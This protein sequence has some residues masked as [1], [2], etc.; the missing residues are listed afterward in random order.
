MAATA[1][2]KLAWGFGG[3][4]MQMEGAWNQGGKSP[5]VFDTAYIDHQTRP[6]YGTPFRSADHYHRMKEDLGYLG[7]LGATAYRFSVAWTRILPNCTGTPN[8]E[9][10]KFYSDMIDEV[11]RQGAEP[12]LT[13]FHWDLPQ[14]CQD[15]FNGWQSDRIIEVFA[16]YANILFDNYGDRVNYWLTS[17]EP[18]ANCD[19]CMYRPKFPPFTTTSDAVYYQ[20]IHNSFLAHATVVR[21]ARARSDSANWKISIPNV[22]DW[23][24]PDPGAA[25]KEYYESTLMQIEWFFDPCFRGDYGPNI[26]RLLPLPEFTPAQQELMK[27]SCDYIGINIYNSMTNDL[28]ADPPGETTSYTSQE[29]GKPSAYWPHPRPEGVRA[30]PKMLYERYE[31]EVVITE[32]GYHVPRSVEETF[33]QAVNDDLRVKYWEMNAP[34]VIALITEDNVPLTAVLAWCLIDNYE[35]ESYEFRWGH[36]AVDC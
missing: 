13:M 8:P 27:N 28:P 33:E 21:N 24:D 4:A 10:I 19:F 26:K 18:R 11:K 5:S 1:P 31:K 34:N 25:A 23:I 20:C 14:S 29:A 6:T 2:V 32:L 7:Q 12:Y 36:I 22:V 35:F 17:N 9:G 3:S 15:Q 30:L 16:D